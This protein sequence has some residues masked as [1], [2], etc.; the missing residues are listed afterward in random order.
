[1]MYIGLSLGRCLSSIMTGEVSESD[2]L[3]IITRTACLDIDSLQ[4]VVREYHSNR[5][6]NAI[7]H[8]ATSG[9]YDLSEFSLDEILDLATRLYD[10][11]KIHQPRLY[12]HSRYNSIGPY[13]SFDTI[14]LEV[15]PIPHTDN[16]AVL[17]A[18]SKYKML[19]TLVK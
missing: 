3:C 9:P 16:V 10:S 13:I 6:M 15:G 4:N 17:D 12:H 2:V 18:Y 1:M 11:G 14:W 8:H 19:A 5:R 7:T